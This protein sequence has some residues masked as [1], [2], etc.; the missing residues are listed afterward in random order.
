MAQYY[1]AQSD[2]VETLEEQVNERL[3]QGWELQGGVSVCVTNNTLTPKIN[4]DIGD[5][6]WYTYLQAMKKDD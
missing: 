2:H 5:Q 6:L 3:K 4:P 1:I